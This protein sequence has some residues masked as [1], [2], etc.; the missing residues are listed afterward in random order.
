MQ[1]VLIDKGV[2]KTNA[3]AQLMAYLG[4]SDLNPDDVA[5]IP[6]PSCEVDM[7]N[8]GVRALTADEVAQLAGELAPK[9]DDVVLTAD[10]F[11]AGWEAARCYFSECLTNV[12]DSHRGEP[13]DG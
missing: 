13:S 7:P 5:L 3:L 10:S 2:G 12:L 1:L 11:E 6:L 8:P 9:E 4:V